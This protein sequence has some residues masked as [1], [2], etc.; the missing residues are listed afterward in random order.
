[1][2]IKIISK[3]RRVLDK[4][5]RALKDKEHR[6]IIGY[7]MGGG[8]STSIG[9]NHPELFTYVGGMCG[10]TG[11]GGLGKL[12]ADPAKASASASSPAAA[13]VRARCSA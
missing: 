3:D 2:A 9:L 13:W 8:H 10:Y 6:A 4:E 11:E 5:F 7:S 1:M 12:L